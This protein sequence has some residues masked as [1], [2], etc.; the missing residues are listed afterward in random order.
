MFEK[1]IT[2][3]AWRFEKKNRLSL[4]QNDVWNYIIF[5]QKYDH[6]KHETVCDY[7]VSSILYITFKAY[8]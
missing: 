2:E 6:T 7:F 1:K 8:M 5:A 3:F 4:L